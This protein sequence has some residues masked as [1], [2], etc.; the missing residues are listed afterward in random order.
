MFVACHLTLTRHFQ[1][2]VHNSRYGIVLPSTRP[3][4]QQ[5]PDIVRAK[6]FSAVPNTKVSRHF[7]GS[8]LYTLSR[9]VPKLHDMKYFGNI[10]FRNASYGYSKNQIRMVGF[11]N[12]ETYNYGRQNS[13]R[14]RLKQHLD[15]EV[16]PSL[17]P[18]K[19]AA[20]TI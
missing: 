15:G 10:L 9:P 16:L 18:I 2:I 14:R 13:Q 8:Q 5:S 19:K 20:S 17:Q 7:T 4:S 6:P 11:V 3:Y 1:R 12:K